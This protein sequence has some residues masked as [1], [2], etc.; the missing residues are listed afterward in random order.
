MVSRKD[1]LPRSL[2]LVCLPS[3]VILLSCWLYGIDEAKIGWRTVS[4]VA[5]S[6]Y[7]RVIP[8]SMFILGASLVIVSTVLYASDVDKK[9]VHSTNKSKIK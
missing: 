5:S 4:T 1:S 8:G 3:R 9:I 7:Y 2:L 6:L